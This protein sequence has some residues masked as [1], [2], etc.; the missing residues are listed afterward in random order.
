[1]KFKKLLAH[2]IVEFYH[3]KNPADL[4]SAHFEKTVQNK[5]VVEEDI[6]NVGVK[7][8]M[9]LFDF[10]RKTLPEDISGNEMKRTVEQ[11]GVEVDGKKVT[12]PLEIIEFKS[13]VLVKYG[14][15]IFLRVS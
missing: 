12:T 9:T 1:M 4:A 15:R 5:D 14:K 11:G 7:G 3:G 8:K 13:G 6:K 10:L 2:N